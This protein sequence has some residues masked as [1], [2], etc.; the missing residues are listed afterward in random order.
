MPFFSIVIPTF[1]QCDF[2][3]VAISSVLNQTYKNYEIIIIDND[4]KDLK[5]HKFLK[6][7]KKNTK[8]NFKRE[9]FN[10]SGDFNFS[11]M[12]N[13]VAKKVNGNVIL[14]LNNDIEFIHANWGFELAANA[15]RPGIGFVG[16]KLLYKDNTI[17][18]AG[19]ILGIGG[20]AGHAFKYLN[21]N[22][23]GYFSRILLPQEF[24]ALTAA[25]LAI[26][27][28]NW[29][30]L[31]GFDDSFLP[32][33]YND[34]DVCLEARVNGLRNL[35][36]PTVQAYHFESKSRGKPKGKRLKLWQKEKKYMLKKWGHILYSDP[37]YS[38]YLTLLREDFSKSMKYPDGSLK[39]RTSLIQRSQKHI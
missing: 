37:S 8:Y 38:P 34:V 14:F 13:K 7:F 18:H 16:A 2:L 33:D 22:N 9:I 31:K 5:T 39:L 3:K 21:K 15:L 10:Y 32:I 29:M 24:S 19:V 30:K 25:C 1:N 11:D 20:V 4:S 12:N 36:L 6:S 28:E 17:Q 26:S 27:K 35:Y 23:K